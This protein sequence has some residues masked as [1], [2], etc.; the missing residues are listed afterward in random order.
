M[1]PILI[2]SAV[3]AADPAEIELSPAEIGKAP[4]VFISAK[5]LPLSLRAPRDGRWVSPEGLEIRAG[6]FLPYPLDVDVKRRLRLLA[7]FPDLCQHELDKLSGYLELK[8]ER[9]LSLQAAEHV[10]NRV[11]AEVLAAE[12]PGWDWYHYAVLGVAV[13]AAAL[14]GYGG[15]I[16]HRG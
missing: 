1:I 8:H 6:E 16:L 5:G 2:S 13:V 3:L 14:A 4:Q 9:A 7:L 12:R 10:V 15:A 11:D